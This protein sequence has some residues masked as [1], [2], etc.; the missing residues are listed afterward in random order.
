M[1]SSRNGTPFRR[2]D[3]AKAFFD[4]DISRSTSKESGPRDRNRPVRTVST[5]NA[6]FLT[7]PVEI[8]LES[9]TSFL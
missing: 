5:S 9:T 3:I 4:L 1:P 2:K 8:R 7:L 6:I